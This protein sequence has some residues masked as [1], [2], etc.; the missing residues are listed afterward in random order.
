VLTINAAATPEGHG[1]QPGAD[2]ALH[3]ARHGLKV[4]VRHVDGADIGAG[5]LLLNEAADLQADLI[6]MGGYGHSRLRELVLGGA[7]RTILR[8]MTAPV[9]LSH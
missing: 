2:I 7:T 5:D 4:T 1:E 3:L 9:L 6:V 8:Q